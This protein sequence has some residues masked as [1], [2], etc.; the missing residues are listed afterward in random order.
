MTL[1]LEND[2]FIEIESPKLCEPALV[3]LGGPSLKRRYPTVSYGVYGVYGVHGVYRVYGVYR[4]HGVL[5]VSRCPTAFRSRFWILVR[6]ITR[7]ETSSEAPPAALQ[8]G[9]LTRS[10]M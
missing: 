5:G 10:P 1:S 2:R 4:V 9:K 8:L 3:I 6:V 7:Q